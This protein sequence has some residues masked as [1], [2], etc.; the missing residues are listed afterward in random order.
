M[1]INGRKRM[2]ETRPLRWGRN[3]S[4]IGDALFVFQMYFEVGVAVVVG[5]LPALLLLLRLF[6]QP[7]KE[8]SVVWVIGAS[9]G[10]GKGRSQCESK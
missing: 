4:L 6:R 9:S 1:R 8:L 10:I 5:I 7:K 2:R 3:I